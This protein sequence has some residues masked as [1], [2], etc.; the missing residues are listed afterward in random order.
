VRLGRDFNALWFG[1][2]VSLF[3]SAVTQ[4][5]LPSVAILTLHATP[6]QVGALNALGYAAFPILG[7]AV[8]VWADRM[9]R[10][11]IMIAADFVRAAVLGWILIAAFFHQVGFAQLAVAA[12]VMGIG[13]VFFDICYQSYLPSLVDRTALPAANA[14]LEFTRSA[15]QIAGSGLA[16]TL[17]AA[18]GATFALGVDALSFLVSIL[19]L[20]FIRTRED[21]AREP[22]TVARSFARELREGLDVVVRSPI[23][24]AISACTATQNFASS[25]SGAVLLIFAYRQLH[26]SPTVMG[27]VF[28]A[29]N[30]GFAGAA[31]AT[32]SQRRFGLGATLALS[33]GAMGVL[34]LCLPLAAVVAPV[35]II[36]T[37]ELL[38]TFLVPIYNI[39]QV[40]LR[41]AIVPQSLQGRM[42]ATIRT[43]VW[44]TMPAGALA[45]G[46]LGNAFGAVPTLIA[47]GVIG[48]LGCCWILTSPVLRLRDAEAAA[49]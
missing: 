43:F 12:T 13:S 19:S 17:I 1:Q 25:M 34:G 30:V 26:L 8:G 46:W 24:R 36:F 10:R 18:I 42:N 15:A 6:L 39:N 14:R 35:P 22:R 20:A 33:S 40:S 9:A 41:Q 37:V 16:G 44:G 29:A 48:S 23:L 3:G 2:T 38:A 5:A 49:A 32:W 11:P 21:F 47:A 28:A 31:L 7:L 45:G 4:L 27:I